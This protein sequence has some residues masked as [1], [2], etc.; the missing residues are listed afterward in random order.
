MYENMI[1]VYGI[2]GIVPLALSKSLSSRPTAGKRRSNAHTHFFSIVQPNTSSSFP[3]GPARAGSS[4]MMSPSQPP[5]AFSPSRPTL[6]ALSLNS[7]AT[8]LTLSP[9]VSTQASSGSATAGTSPTH[10]SDSGGMKRL[11][12]R[13][14]PM[15]AGR[16][17]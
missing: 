13:A 11:R 3:S 6:L 8:S 10:S 15:S 9:K 16:R 5:S 1:T 7:S 17:T 14:E 4:D 2:L 12:V